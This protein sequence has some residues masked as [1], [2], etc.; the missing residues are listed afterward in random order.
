MKKLFLFLLCLVTATNVETSPIHPV[1]FLRNIPAAGSSAPVPDLLWYKFTEGTGT[2]VAD[3]VGGHTGTFVSTP[4]WTT[5]P[6]GHG[7]LQFTSNL[8]RVSFSGPAAGTTFTLSMW[9]FPIPSSASY[10]NLFGVGNTKGLFYSGSTKKLN[11]Y[12]AG[13]GFGTTVMTENNWYHVCI[14]VSAGSATYY[15]NGATAGTRSSVTSYTPTTMGGDSSNENLNGKI[16]D[17]EMFSTALNSTQV[18]ALYTAGAN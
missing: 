15:L 13:D 8:Q 6:T 18:N 11:F 10:A 12:D 5:G 17:V 7:A 1:G 9:I 2:T 3:S 16:A 14:V 4:S